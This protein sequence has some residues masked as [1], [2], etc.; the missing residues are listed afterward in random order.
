MEKG[1]GARGDGSPPWR[2]GHPTT[3]PVCPPQEW[4]ARTDVGGT[5]SHHVL[6]VVD[7]GVRDPGLGL[8]RGDHEEFL[9][10]G[11]DRK[12]CEMQGGR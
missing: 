1:D 6:V 4:P 7:A 2:P 3:S 8:I 11:E 9:G 12:E 5:L 10:A